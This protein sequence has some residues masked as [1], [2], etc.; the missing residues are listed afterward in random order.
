LAVVVS[1]DP[2]LPGPSLPDPIVA[3][4]AR[5]T[6]WVQIGQ[7][8]G[9]GC[10]LLAMVAFAVGALTG[11]PGYAVTAS[12]TGLVAACVILPVPIVAGYGVRAAER[13]ERNERRAR[14]KPPDATHQ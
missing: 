10:L 14:A 5:V 3:R 12:I 9:Y 6:Y 1:D 4:R 8:V 7:R 2:I 11:F 13:D